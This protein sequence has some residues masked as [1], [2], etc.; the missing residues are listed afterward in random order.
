VTAADDLRP[1]A[2]DLARTLAA[3][4]WL[5]QHRHGLEWSEEGRAR[6]CGLSE[7][8]GWYVDAQGPTVYAAAKALQR[9]LAW[10]ARRDSTEGAEEIHD[11]A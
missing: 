9:R 2:P 8:G 3:L 6:C 1:D 10:Y 5:R 7:H 4:R 11:G